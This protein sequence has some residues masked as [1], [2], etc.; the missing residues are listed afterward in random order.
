[1]RFLFHFNVSFTF[2]SRSNLRHILVFYIYSFILSSMHLYIC[3]FHPFRLVIT[4]LVLLVPVVS[5]P[6]IS[7]LGVTGLVSSL[8]SGSK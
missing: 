5:H 7:E 2:T 3:A 6:E 4:L 1:M 8:H